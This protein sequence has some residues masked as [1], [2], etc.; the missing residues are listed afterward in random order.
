ML[1]DFDT[2]VDLDLLVIH[3]DAD[4]WEHTP[5]RV[6]VNDGGGV[7]RGVTMDMC[8]VQEVYSIGTNR[9]LVADF[10]GDGR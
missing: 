5:A 2:D 8:P 4:T 6:L 9:L 7:L 3:I 1:I 10:N